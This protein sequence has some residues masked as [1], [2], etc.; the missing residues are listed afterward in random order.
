MENF[1]GEHDDQ[2]S[3]RWIFGNHSDFHQA[4]VFGLVIGALS[5]WGKENSWLS[6]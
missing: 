1:N 2:A 6:S 4:F 3:K 5:H